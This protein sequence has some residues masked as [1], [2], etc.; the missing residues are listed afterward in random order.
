MTTPNKTCPFCGSEAEPGEEHGG[1]YFIRCTNI[2]CDAQGGGETDIDAAWEV[3][4]R[5][6]VE[7]NSAAAT[8]ARIKE[9]SKDLVI[10][11]DGHVYFR[12]PDGSLEIS[13]ESDAACRAIAR[14]VIRYRDAQE[15]AAEAENA[16]ET[17]PSMTPLEAMAAAIHDTDEG[18]E[19][20]PSKNKI[21][22]EM[23]RAALLALAGC[24]DLDRAVIEAA[25]FGDEDHARR[26]EKDFRAVC[27]ALAEDGGK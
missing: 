8:L 11:D 17:R 24:E 20:D 22:M 7:P 5:R 23:A 16:G 1:Y 10:H 27:R 15:R 9:L 21:V 4:N 14:E 26:I 13:A 19:F 3:W 6:P 18:S 2:N 12:T 25:D